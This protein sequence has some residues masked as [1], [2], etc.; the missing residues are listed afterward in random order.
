MRSNFTAEALLCNSKILI[1]GKNKELY[2][3]TLPILKDKI[4]NLD[5]DIFV[6]FC[7]TDLKEFNVA[8]GLDI[9]DKLSLFKLYKDQ[10]QKEIVKVLEKYFKKYMVGFHYED[11]QMFWGNR[12][13]SKDLFSLFCDYCAI[14]L[15]Y[16]RIE[17]L[18]LIIT[19]DMDEVTKRQI[20]L[21]RR[22]AATK[23]KNGGANSSTSLEK[24]LTGVCQEFG[25]KYS[26]LYE[27]TLFGI[28]HMY[29]HIG[30]IMNY[31]INNI[32]AGNGLL[33]KNSKHKHWAT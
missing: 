20:M 33:K 22:I 19:S 31:Q 13:V 30:E 11:D 27:M 14:A 4:E 15:G 29:S 17:E 16:K 28:Y 10:K 18:K 12:I 9:K 2:V 26:D 5:Y 6:G 21:E 32:A 24:I 7:A 23:A 1:E 3:M 8:S 25:Y